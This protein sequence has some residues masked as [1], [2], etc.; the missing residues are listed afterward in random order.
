MPSVYDSWT[1]QQLLTKDILQFRIDHNGTV[2]RQI[3]TI[4]I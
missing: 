1:E 2:W 4:F 3:L